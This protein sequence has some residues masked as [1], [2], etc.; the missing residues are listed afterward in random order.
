MTNKYSELMEKVA[1]LDEKREQFIKDLQKDVKELEELKSKYEKDVLSGQN[2]RG[3]SKKISELESKI[4]SNEKVKEIYQKTKSPNYTRGKSK[5]EY[6]TYKSNKDIYKLAQEVIA[7]NRELAEQQKEQHSNLAN[8]LA[9]L[10]EAYL[11]KVE[12]LGQ[13]VKANKKTVNELREATNYTDTKKSIYGLKINERIIPH[14][15][16]GII[17][18]S[19]NESDLA[20]QDGYDQAKGWANIHYTNKYAL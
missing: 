2:P 14:R 8:E 3:L 1:E 10:K 19:I 17:Y 5:A 11:K 15:H 13:V 16:E 4:S 20:Y 12:E 7:E 9:E 6:Q 18:I